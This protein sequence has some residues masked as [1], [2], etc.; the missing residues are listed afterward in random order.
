VQWSYSARDVHD[1]ASGYHVK[2][3][4]AG[5]GWVVVRQHED[6]LFPAGGAR[7]DRI[8]DEGVNKETFKRACSGGIEV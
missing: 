3:V 7:E 4:T 5:S 8:G 2:R 1:K 6:N